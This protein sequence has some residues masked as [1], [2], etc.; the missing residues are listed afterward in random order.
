MVEARGTIWVA[1]GTGV[2]VAELYRR[3]SKW[4]ECGGD[5]ARRVMERAD[6]RTSL[7]FTGAELNLEDEKRIEKLLFDIR[8]VS[9]EEERAL[10]E[11]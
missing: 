5:F 2:T 4:L 7:Q 10:R 3:A 1:P 6:V 8:D 11:R 9:I